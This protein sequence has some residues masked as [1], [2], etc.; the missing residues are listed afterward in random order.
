MERR[1]LHREKQR[2]SES[3]MGKVV[4]TFVHTIGNAP[5][6]AMTGLVYDKLDTYSTSVNKSHECKYDK[7]KEDYDHIDESDI[8]QKRDS[9]NLKEIIKTLATQ[10]QEI[11]RLGKEKNSE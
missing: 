1:T 5:L 6:I 11:R 9:Y 3:V 8:R 2:I 7:T 4:D 10:T